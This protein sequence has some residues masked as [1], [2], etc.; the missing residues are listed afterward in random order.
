MKGI[1][2]DDDRWNGTLDGDI[3]AADTMVA[4]GPR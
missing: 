1:S 3:A 4:A 2:D